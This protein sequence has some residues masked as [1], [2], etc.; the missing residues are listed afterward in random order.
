MFKYILLLIISLPA[1][2]Q[3]T[4][5]PDFN[6]A[7]KI[8]KKFDIFNQE[9]LY[10]GCKISGNKVDKSSC[11]YQ[12]PKS[13][14]RAGRVEWEHVVPHSFMARSFKYDKK[15]CGK[16]AKRN[17]LEDS[18][19]ELSFMVSDLYN[20]FAEDGYINALRS[21]KPIEE[22][23]SSDVSFGKCDIKM[24][25]RGFTP[26]KEVK[27]QVARVFLYMQSAYPKV[28]IISNKNQK[29]YE[30]WDKMYP[31]SKSECERVKFIEKLQNNENKIVKPQCV[32]AKLW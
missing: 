28:N 26:R 6:N 3:N 12:E 21:N 16:K 22:L 2:A 15:A 7:K 31:V 17:C 25:K 20:L 19:P 14:P 24:N 29:L 23:S 9:T 10:C 13:S 30:A 1:F 5:V 4:R 18:Y 11:G 27:G 32:A 8:L